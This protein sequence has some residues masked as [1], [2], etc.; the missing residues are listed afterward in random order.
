MKNKLLAKLGVS[1]TF[2]TEGVSFQFEDES[3]E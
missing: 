1:P 2:D 3:P